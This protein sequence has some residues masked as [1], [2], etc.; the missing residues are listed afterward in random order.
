MSF[1]YSTAYLVLSDE[2]AFGFI[3]LYLNR[4]YAGLTD[5]SE[6]YSGT[7]DYV[8]EMLL[9]LVDKGSEHTRNVF[10]RE[11]YL[12][13]A[14]ARVY[15][16]IEQGRYDF[17][18]GVL[19]PV[20]AALPSGSVVLDVGA[21]FNRFMPR[22]AGLAGREDIKYYASDPYVTPEGQD[23]RVP[24]IAQPGPYQLPEEAG[25]CDL[26]VFRAVM[27]HAVRLEL[28]IDEV[29][30]VLRPGGKLLLIEDSFD[31]GDDAIWDGIVPMV[32]QVLVGAFNDLTAEKKLDFLKFNDWYSNRLYHDWSGMALPFNHKPLSAWRDELARLGMKLEESFNLGFPNNDYA[33]HQ[34]FT[35]AM[36]FGRQ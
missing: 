27:H 6:V 26:I 36:I 23:S 3:R 8:K 24:F 13:R 11:E 21:G 16:R 32:D 5:N 29:R 20:I 31:D 19:L 14:H 12:S 2:T 7:D 9:S 22:L 18:A 28:M 10:F 35:L 34:P 17:D 30:R 25:Q 1:D 33:V 15:G 4:R